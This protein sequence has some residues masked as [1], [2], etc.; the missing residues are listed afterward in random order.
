MSVMDHP[1]RTRTRAEPA[2]PPPV[3]P[4]A[5]R[6]RSLRPGVFGVLDVGS[7]KITCLIGRADA[8]GG[9]R[10]LG[11]GLQRSGGVRSGGI[12]DLREAERAIREA[13]AQAETA[14]ETRLRS[15]VVNLACGQPESRLLAVHCPVGGRPVTETDMR[16]AVAEGRAA[17]PPAEG[18]ELVH[19]LP[20]SFSVDDVGAV[21]DPRGHHCDVL[22]ARVHLVDAARA[23]LRNLG[24]AVAACDLEI[25]ELVS[26]PMAAGLSCLV[27]DEREL[28]C[29][30]VDMGGGV[31]AVGVFGEG[32][33]LHTAQV[34]VG[35]LHV[36]RDIADLLSTPLASAER[37]KTMYGTA[38][39]SPDDEREMLTVQQIGEEDH[40]FARIPRSALVEVIRPRLEETFE[41]VRD[42]LDAAGLGRSAGSRVVLTGGASQLVGVREMAHRVLERQVRLGRPGG[43]RGLV[44]PLDGPDF[45]CA[46]GLL[47]WAAGRHRPLPELDLAAEAQ[48]PGL[49]RRLA[50]FLR[51]RV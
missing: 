15:V 50:A 26:A 1:T 17:G 7:T 8:E 22:G 29:T 30:V 12:N 43:V 3:R 28:G 37:L 44:K 18:R 5:P 16:R 14:A 35:G 46:T 31:T 24:G 40:A 21:A 42:R 41:L 36:S 47:A 27:E 9:L 38:E 4:D 11:A 19:A 10:L 6:P 13:V 51:E 23:A 34:P 32:G 2:E 33:L 48:P 25:A 49:L 39:P 20:V 45:A